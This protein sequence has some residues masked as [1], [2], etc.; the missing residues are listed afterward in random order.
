MGSELL[1]SLNK[2]ERGD[3]TV[4]VDIACWLVIGE[5]SG[6]VAITECELSH[7]Q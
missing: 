7:E 6:T 5:W 2:G 3:L 4:C 1:V